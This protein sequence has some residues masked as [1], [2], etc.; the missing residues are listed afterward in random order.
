[1]GRRWGQAEGSQGMAGR[2]L[3]PPQIHSH[4]SL[5]QNTVLGGVGERAKF[6]LVQHGEQM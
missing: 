1:M 2:G 5:G 3:T 6:L 4:G